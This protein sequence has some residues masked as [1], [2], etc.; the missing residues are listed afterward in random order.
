MST[1]VNSDSY[2]FLIHHIRG[3][4]EYLKIKHTSEL[5]SEDYKYLNLIIAQKYSP[6]YQ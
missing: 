1:L 5:I 2:G 3:L 6:K 4:L